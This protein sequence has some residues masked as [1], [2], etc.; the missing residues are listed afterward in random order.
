MR[1][2]T[3][4]RPAQGLSLD[5]L[6]PVEGRAGRLFQVVYAILVVHFGSLAVTYL[7]DPGSAVR[8]FSW[9]NQRLGGVP[10]SPPDVAPWRLATAVGMATLT[11]MCLLLL[12]DLRRNHPIL[13]PAAFFKGFNALL[14]FGYYRDSRLPVFLLAGIIDVAIVAIMLV[15]ARAALRSADPRAES[16]PA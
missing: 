12:V 1:A 10:I 6:R 16:R 13:L 15:T 14:W 5:R 8:G 11:L 4:A 2:T 9:A 3:E 7:V